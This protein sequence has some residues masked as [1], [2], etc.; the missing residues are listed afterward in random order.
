MIRSHAKRAAKRGP[1]RKPGR[2]AKGGSKYTVKLTDAVA[3]SLRALGGGV[4]TRGIETAAHIAATR[5]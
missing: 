1:R 5:S 2:P 3:D 4:L